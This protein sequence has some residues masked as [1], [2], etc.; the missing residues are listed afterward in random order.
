MAA[1]DTP[2]EL[3]PTVNGAKVMN[4]AG[5]TAGKS[6]GV[7]ITNNIYNPLPEK[8]SDSVAKT[9]RRQARLGL[10]GG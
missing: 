6:G 1:A 8:G 9:Q 2:F 10:F 5:L 4:S 7:D 3:T